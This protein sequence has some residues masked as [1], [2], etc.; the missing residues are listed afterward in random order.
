MTR[1]KILAPRPVLLSISFYLLSTALL[2]DAYNLKPL[3]STTNEQLPK[4]PFR[5]MIDVD[6]A[7]SHLNA[8]PTKPGYGYGRYSYIPSVAVDGGNDQD[9]DHQESFRQW[10]SRIANF[11]NIA[12]LLCV[13]DCTVLPI[14]T[15]IF[16]MIGFVTSPTQLDWIH[17]LGHSIAIYFVIPVGGSAALMNYLSH[18]RLLLSTP[19]LIGLSMIYLVNG[20]GGPI[21]SKLPNE[22]IDSLRYGTILHQATNIAGCALLLGSNYVSHRAGHL[23]ANGKSCG[24]WDCRSEG[25]SFFSW[26]P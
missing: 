15:V 12:S 22:L 26:E 25:N 16:P 9:V 6:T 1:V 2:V 21:L 7:P 14:V 23:H 11:S 3:P 10:R 8:P 19:A 17:E 4:M 18:K 13:V 5:K 24:R 20:H